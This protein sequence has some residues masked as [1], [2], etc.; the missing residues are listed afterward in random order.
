MWVIDAVDLNGSFRAIKIKCTCNSVLGEGL[1]NE[2]EH[3]C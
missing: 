1:I 3:T 2:T